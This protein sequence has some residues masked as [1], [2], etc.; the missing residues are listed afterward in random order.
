[1][2]K[3]TYGHD[4]YKDRHRKTIYS[5]R[6]VL[7][8]VLDALPPVHSAI[9]FGCG[10]G[11]WLSVLKEKGVKEILG[12]DGPWVDQNLLEIPKRD[13][14]EVDFEK[15][16]SSKKKY[17]LAMTLEVAEHLPQENAVSFVESLVIA[18]DFVLFSAAIPFQGGQSHINEQW[19]DYW[20]DM[21]AER[22]YAPLDLVR[23]K[24]WNDKRIPIWYRQN[25]LLF[26]KQKQLRRVR[27]PALNRHDGNLPISLVHPD[28]YLSKINQ[29]LSVKGSWKLFGRALKR[30]IKK[31]IVGSS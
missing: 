21:F 8:I 4:F 5:A 24:I 26:V 3:N 29:T 16:V 12:L 28:T 10:V 13:F 20:A 25:I 14:R 23:R 9:D 31:R 22:E 15:K 11:T 7:S 27:V 18:S 30:Y 17:D 6:T 19:P 1:M 2:I